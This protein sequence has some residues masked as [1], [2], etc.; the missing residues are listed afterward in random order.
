MSTSNGPQPP[1]GPPPG[2]FPQPFPPPF[3]PPPMMF[4]PPVIQRERGGFA[5]AIF[6]TLA[7]TIFGFSITLNIYLLLVQSMLS[8]SDSGVDRTILQTGDDQT[9]VAVIPL[10]GMIQESSARRFKSLLREVRNDNCVKAVVIELN[11]PGGTVTASDD[12]YNEILSLKQDRGIPVF[13][14]MSELGTSGGY[15]VA[16]AA[17]QVFAQ[18]TTWTGNIGVLM[19]RISLNKLAEKWGIED[20]TIS[21]TG[22]EFKHAG[23]T[24][25]DPSPE[26]RAY[27]QGLIDDAFEIFKGVVVTGRKLDKATVDKLANGKVYS[28]SDALKLKLVDSLGNLDDAIAAAG[29]KAA[30]AKPHVVRLEKHQS[31][32]ERLSGG[33]DAS[34]GKFA[35]VKLGDT[36]IKIDSSI[37]EN[38]LSPR[39]LYLWCGD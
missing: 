25:K 29:A 31:F 3:F 33:T 19:P 9:Q 17:D 1:Y 2:Q 27:W 36:E 26:Q 35:S 11:S 24:F 7:V 14:S 18:K 5:R 28:G 21:S 4:Q 12:I 20:Q 39:P 16:C 13:L 23:S 10:K 32:V 6:T 34:E 38:V 22:A 15:Y 37:A 30:I 8:G